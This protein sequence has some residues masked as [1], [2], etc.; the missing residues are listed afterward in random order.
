MARFT[1]LSNCINTQVPNGPTNDERDVS[2][3][4]TGDMGTGQAAVVYLLM[5]PERVVNSCGLY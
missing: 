4:Y 2:F 5:L 3:D 1:A